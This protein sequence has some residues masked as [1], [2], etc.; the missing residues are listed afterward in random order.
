M[1][2]RTIEMLGLVLTLLVLLGILLACTPTQGNPTPTPL[3]IPIQLPTPPAQATQFALQAPAGAKVITAFSEMD[4]ACLEKTEWT[5]EVTPDTWLDVGI[6]WYA[7]D[8]PTAQEN[9]KHLS[10][11]ITLDGKEIKDFG[12][13]YH[14]PKPF[15][16]DCPKSPI[17]AEMVG[18]EIYVPPLPVGEHKITWEVTIES[19]L[20]DGWDNI[21][22]GPATIFASTVRVAP[23]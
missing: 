22:K 21:P 17:S 19:D 16:L 20:N 6:I 18:L 13:Y 7:K 4:A 5:V 11:V 1:R 9:W 2:T 3:A 14:G 12:K 15:K 10:I 23:K 8:G